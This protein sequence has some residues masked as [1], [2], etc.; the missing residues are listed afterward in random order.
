M[1][2]FVLLRNSSDLLQI[3]NGLDYFMFFVLLSSFQY[4]KHKIP[5]KKTTHKIKTKNVICPLKILNYITN[6]VA[7]VDPFI[8]FRCFVGHV[9][10]LL[11]D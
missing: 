4:S 8:A 9:N 1:L 5:K 3:K 6:N 10:A 2:V 7:D 11:G